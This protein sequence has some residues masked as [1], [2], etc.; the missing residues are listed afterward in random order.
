MA[1]PKK[2]SVEEILAACRKADGAP[3]AGTSKAIDQPPQ[4]QPGKAAAPDV[5]SVEPEPNVESVEAASA[6]EVPAVAPPAPSGK[7]PSEMSVAEMLAAA[8]SQKS[9]SA[10]AKSAAET[11]SA[12]KAGA[13]PAAKPAAAGKK[14]GQMSVAEMLAAARAEKSGGAAKATEKKAPAAAKKAVAEAPAAVAAKPTAAKPAAPQPSGPKDTASILATARKTTKPGPITKAEAAAKEKAGV[15]VAPKPAKPKIEVP[16]MPEKP[17][18]ARPAPAPAPAAQPD[19]RGFLAGF[20]G[21]L[22]GTPLAL[23]FSSL[24]ITHLLWLLG[25]ARFM[26]PNI[27]TEPPT[28]FKVGF[29]DDLAP[30]QV[31]TKYIAQY[32]VWIVRYEYE[33]QP[34]IY[35]LKSVCTHLGCTPNWLEAEQKFKCPCHGS[36]FYKD[37]IN[38]EGPAPRPLERHAIRVAEDGQLEV[39]KS[40]TFFEEKGEWKDSASYVLV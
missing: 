32:G 33:G 24:A 14:P 31:E 40:R 38:F 22:V 6:E 3:G 27:L 28:K 26:F 19:R 30:G 36:G 23:G 18:Y 12:T 17:A 35:A 7:K 21:V 9:G 37:G 13:I 39:D 2:M 29:P 16:P 25:L 20:L 11:K 34:E 5:E 8:R 10:K 1:D 15:A 4:D